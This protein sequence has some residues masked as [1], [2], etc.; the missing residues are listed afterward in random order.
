MPES[1]QDRLKRVRPPRV[2][3]DYK[4][5]TEG[6]EPI[7]ELPFIVGVMADLSGQAKE[8]VKKPM[9]QRKFIEID[10]DSFNRVMSQQQPRL[11]FKVDNKLT[12]DGTEKLNVE[13]NFRSMQDFEPARLAEQVPV[14]N[15][16]LQMRKKLTELLSK[17]E[18]NDALEK[19][20]GDVMQ[21]TEKRQALADL[22]GKK[23]EPPAQA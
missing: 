6:A 9:K 2:K 1:Y 17:M 23:E 21:S 22:L 8:G 15:E 11:A 14:L 13:L 19:L 16:L 18:G 20:L 4:V 10:R 5:E 7:T 12:G 3:I